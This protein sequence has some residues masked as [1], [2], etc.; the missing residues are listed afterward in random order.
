M[1]IFFHRKSILIWLFQFKY[2]FLSGFT[3][4][5]FAD[6]SG[7]RKGNDY[8]KKLLGNLKTFYLYFTNYELVFI[9]DRYLDISFISEN[10]I[11][12]HYF[13]SWH[14]LTVAF[15]YKNISCL[16]LMEKIAFR[17][18]AIHFNLKVQASMNGLF[19]DVTII[20]GWDDLFFIHPNIF[21][22]HELNI[23]NPFEPIHFSWITKGKFILIVIYSTFH[24]IKFSK[25]YLLICSIHWK[26]QL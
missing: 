19:K 7:S 11:L 10:S 2:S 4:V 22:D 21:R 12:N 5:V 17:K 15:H 24:R 16:S 18:L 1:N 13:K 6:Y 14:S 20:Q 8:R 25:L 26:Q 3:A 9:L 23:Q